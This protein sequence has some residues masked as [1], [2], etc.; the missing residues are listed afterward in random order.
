[1]AETDRNRTDN[2]ARALAAERERAQ[3]YL[4]NEMAKLGLR[5][6]DGWSINES[7]REDAGGT[8]IV[9]RPIHLR[10]TPPQDLECVVGV[11]EEDGCIT[12]RCVG[13]DG[14]PVQVS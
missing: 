5:K 7:M 3:R 14:N 9:L 2:L 13:A 8:Q 4:W 1:M 10:L 6:E 12:G 11:V